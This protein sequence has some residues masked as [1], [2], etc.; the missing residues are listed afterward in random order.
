MPL[1]EY[2]LVPTLGPEPP[3]PDHYRDY[4]AL[5]PAAIESF[6]ISPLL[7]SGDILQIV[8]NFQTKTFAGQYKISAWI[9]VVLRLI[10]WAPF[11]PWVAGVVDVREAFTVSSATFFV[12]FAAAAL[13]SLW[14]RDVPSKVAVP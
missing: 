8:M 12:P 5:K 9:G 2:A 4:Y 1:R 7:F 10:D 6:I 14:Y 13:Q 3:R 11:V